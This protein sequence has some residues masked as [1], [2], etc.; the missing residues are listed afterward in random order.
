MED[1]RRGRGGSIGDD[2]AELQLELLVVLDTVEMEV[3]EARLL[4]LESE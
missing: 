1:S 3:M 4:A 2:T